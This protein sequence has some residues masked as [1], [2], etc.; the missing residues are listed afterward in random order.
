MPQ[1]LNDYQSLL[2]SKDRVV[3]V[4]EDDTE[5]TEDC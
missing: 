5:G 1:K 4:T 2:V 3:L